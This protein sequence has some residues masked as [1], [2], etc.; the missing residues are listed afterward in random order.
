MPQIRRACFC[1]RYA[2]YYVSAIV[3]DGTVEEELAS[4]PTRNRR[5]Q[6]VSL[7]E[8]SHTSVTR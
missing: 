3:N 6:L 4:S 8:Y 5:V 1:K 2:V 7:L